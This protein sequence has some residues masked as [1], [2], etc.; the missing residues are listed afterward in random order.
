LNVFGQLVGTVHV[1]ISGQVDVEPVGEPSAAAT[2]TMA[3]AKGYGPEYPAVPYQDS[4]N[5]F[6]VVVA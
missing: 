5:T 3:D 4:R 1:N 2:W 6:L